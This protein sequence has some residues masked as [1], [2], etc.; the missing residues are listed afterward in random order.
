MRVLLIGCGCVGRVLADNMDRMEEIEGFYVY[1]AVKRNAETMARDFSKSK[2]SEDP[3]KNI[4]EVDLVI[5]AASQDAVAE[6]GPKTLKRGRDFMILSVG[7]LGDEKLKKEMFKLAK[8]NGG[9]IYIPS[10]AVCGVDVLNAASVANID[11][12]ELETVKPPRSL[13]DSD[14]IVKN[15]I[16]LNNL[17]EKMVV[18]EGSAR[19][20]V[21]AFPRNVN[22]SATLSLAGPGFDKTR[23]K[24]IVDPNAKRN[25]HRV[26]I[27]GAFG[28]LECYVENV[29]S[30]ENPRTS[31]LAAISAVA[32]LK[33]I[34]TGVWIGV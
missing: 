16:N 6:F 19:E 15:N 12:V 33:R 26:R 34:A 8:R 11:S 24:V 2:I 22:V 27:R 14:Y 3:V 28:I 1:D 29:P 20:A 9:K 31:Y 5:E 18:F 30:P 10:G 32:T 23:V 4:S 13:K 21:K 17:N 7:A 25:V